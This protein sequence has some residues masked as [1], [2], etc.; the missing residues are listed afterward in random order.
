MDT[1]RAKVLADINDGR[2]K[3]SVALKHILDLIDLLSIVHEPVVEPEPVPV[4]EP[5]P[6]PEPV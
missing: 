1:L 6:E 5:E 2:L 3:K 4:V